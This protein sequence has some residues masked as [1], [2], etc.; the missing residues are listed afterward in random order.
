MLLLCTNAA[1]MSTLQDG[2]GRRA[3]TADPAG[4]SASQSRPSAGFGRSVPH[5]AAWDPSVDTS[6][7]ASVGSE[8]T[9]PA[10]LVIAD[11]VLRSCPAL[12]RTHTRCSVTALLAR[13]C[14]AIPLT[15]CTEG[16]C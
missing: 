11:G 8:C 5:D 10:M 13:M 6:R 16:V 2:C 7:A 4:G 15:L 9:A 1:E 3:S 12:R 14:P